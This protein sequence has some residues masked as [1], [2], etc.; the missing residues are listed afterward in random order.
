M[1]LSRQR[2]T[3]LRVAALCLAFCCLPLAAAPAG[4]QEKTGNAVDILPAKSFTGDPALISGSEETHPPVRLTPD[5]SE[6]IR[7]EKEAASILIG[8]PQHLTVIADTAKRLVL[9]PQVAG[10]TYL[11]VL[12]AMGEVIMQRHVIVASPKERY[13]R[14]RRACASADGQQ[15]CQETSVYFCPDMCHQVNVVVQESESD[16]SPFDALE[17]LAEAVTEGGLP[18]EEGDQGGPDGAGL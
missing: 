18:D 12:D 15:G 7:L 16:D 10:A 3:L 13:V 1:M 17:A 4:A 11:T 5:K 8:N 9:V 2:F 14:V 6:I